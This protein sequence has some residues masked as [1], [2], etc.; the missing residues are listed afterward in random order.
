MAV[1]KTRSIWFWQ[2]I[3]SPHMAGLAVALSRRGCEVTYVARHALSEDR[4]RQGWSTPPL[5]GVN[6]HMVGSPSA[7]E[8]QVA[9]ASADSLHLCGGLRGHGLIG[10]AQQFL[11]RRRLSQW[12]VMETVDDAGWTGALKRLEYGR[13]FRRW[14]GRLQGVLSI[15]H[16]TSDWVRAR[17]MPE[18]AVFPFAYFL[19]ADVREPSDRPQPQG[20]FRFLFVGQL[21]ERKRVDLLL[22]TLEGLTQR[23]FRLAVVGAGSRE[24]S[25]RAMAASTLPGRLDWLGA[26][27]MAAVRAEMVRADC[28]VLPSRHDGWGAVVS[29]S[30]MVGTPVICSDACGA[31]DVV[32]ASGQGG[33]FRR[34]DSAGLAA[35]LDRA[36]AKGTPVLAE[37]RSLATWAKCLDADAGADYL[38]RILD[39]VDGEEQLPPPPWT[40]E[41]QG[42]R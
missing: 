7:V 38:L 15:G 8:E 33:V 2:G 6:V 19:P 40:R 27:P 35:L 16:A 4:A 25:L 39:H 5:G 34:A 21:I 13:L 42:G 3:I 37:R 17:G 10:V 41:L 28:L 11:A 22:K 20:P 29:E 26:L 14:R 23:D 18:R 9:A 24:A 36:I 12:V 30:L 32:Q 1:L 31:A